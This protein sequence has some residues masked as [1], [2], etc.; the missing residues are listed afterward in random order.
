MQ[1]KLMQATFLLV[2]RMGIGRTVT[3]VCFIHPIVKCDS[4]QLSTERM[5]SS[6]CSP[7]ESLTPSWY[8]R[9]QDPD[10]SRH[11]I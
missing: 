1:C 6:C 7:T 8:L 9:L 10:L 5:R 11:P 4:V 2:S 3:E